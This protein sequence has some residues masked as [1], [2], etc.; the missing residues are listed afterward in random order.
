[1]NDIIE[2]PEIIK[3]AALKPDTTKPEPKVEV[4]QTYVSKDGW[5]MRKDKDGFNFPVRDMNETEKRDDKKEIQRIILQ[6]VS[7]NTL[8]KKPLLKLLREQNPTINPT[9]LNRQLN[10]LLK[11]R[12]VEIDR[13]FKTKPFIVKGKY[14]REI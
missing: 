1:M 13:K 3:Q 10:N 9:S 11:S 4:G 14:W 2:I 12:V 8:K 7:A 5:L 6:T